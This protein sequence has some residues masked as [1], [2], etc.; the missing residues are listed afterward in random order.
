[1]VFIRGINS[2]FPVHEKLANLHSLKGTT[3]E[4][5]LFLNGRETLSS[6]KLTWVKMRS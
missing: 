1:M 5:N 3:S 6:L 2:A 4:G